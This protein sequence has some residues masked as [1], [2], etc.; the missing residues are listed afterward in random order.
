MIQKAAIYCRVSSDDQCCD[1]QEI[2]L[3][4]FA[5]KAGYEVV[6]IWKEKGSGV[7]IDRKERK[8]V[9]ALAQ[10]RD[11]DIVL[12][13]ELNR[14][15]R[16]VVDLI[17]TLE[18]LQSW[19]VSVIT[20]SGLQVD[21]ST[22]HGRLIAGMFA[23]LAAFERDLLGERIKSGVAAARKKGKRSGRKYG[24][25]PTSDRI[26]SRVLAFREQGKSYRWIAKEFHVS[27]NTVIS[28]VKKSIK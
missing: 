17:H 27:P 24:F 19:G 9:L 25:C 18:D 23:Q 5:A 6:G 16:S 10:R 26:A 3:L 2:D 20:Q 21:L 8:K 15:S 13:T 12:I 28:I 11:I 4:N 7:R 14:W 22:A 1:R